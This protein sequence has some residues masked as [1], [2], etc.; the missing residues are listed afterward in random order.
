MAFL[1]TNIGRLPFWISLHISPTTMV[2]AVAFT[3][4]GAAVAGVMPAFKLT[5]GMSD[6]LKQS[7]AGSGGLQFGGVWT[8]IIVAQI[9]VTMLFPAIVY[10]ERLMLGRVDDFDM[11]FAAEEYLTA[12]I[13]KDPA[14]QPAR[15][16]QSLE[17]LQARLAA[18]PGVTGV[19]YA[20]SLPATGHPERS[21]E[22]QGSAGQATT[23]W[24][25]VAA[26][27]PSYFEALATAV[28]AG[29]AFTT[30]DVQ[31]GARIAIVDQGFVDLVLQ[32]RNPI[33]QQVRFVPRGDAPAST[34]GPWYEVVGLVKELGL[35][36][37]FQRASRVAG[38]YLASPPGRLSD[39]YLMVHLPSGDPATFGT[40]L[41]EIATAVDSTLRVT[42]VRRADA[43]NGDIVW[44]MAL[45]LRITTVMS[46]LAVVLS[47]AG[48]YSVLAFTVSRRTREI[49]VRVALGGSR[50]R[51][52]GAV[53]RRPLM[54]VGFG[55][56]VGGALVL[57]AVFGLKH[58]EMPGADAPLTAAH[59]ATIAGY[60]LVMVGV[61]SLA[62]IVPAR[63]AL[64]VEPTVALRA[65]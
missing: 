61:C 63:R 47:L 26:V 65:E 57:A 11:G 38:L 10:G 27:T 18:T 24:A 34:P 16:A 30:A 32:G 41:R 22:L 28:I 58:S 5:R 39:Q 23:T 45:W 20:Q 40:R 15:F 64:R 59:F 1:E 14:A 17:E 55:V 4:F 2:F 19:T 7:S 56:L 43:L 49:G 60:V 48:I 53:L 33:G 37:P 12:R 29:R 13:E 31:S 46:V 9:G 62:V 44:V 25:S 8:V 21:I 36:A 42:E 3:V 6:R 54:R 50:E 35:N 52:I 51:V